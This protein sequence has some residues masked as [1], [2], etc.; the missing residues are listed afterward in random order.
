MKETSILEKY[1]K[2]IYDLIDN[3]QL[4]SQSDIDDIIADL[5]KLRDEITEEDMQERA[6]CLEEVID[7]LR[8]YEFVENI[9]ELDINEDDYKNEDDYYKEANEIMINENQDIEDE[10]RDILTSLLF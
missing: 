2:I 4:N 8:I 6:E 10:I 3:L 7:N 5:Q 1:K 9:E